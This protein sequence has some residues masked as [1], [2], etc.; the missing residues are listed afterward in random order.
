MC[1]RA[2]AGAE[3]SKRH[4][5]VQGA[6]F[7][8]QRVPQ[9]SIEKQKRWKEPPLGNPDFTTNVKVALR[10]QCTRPGLPKGNHLR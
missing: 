6:M 3:E 8:S 10:N 2:S 5:D 4:G 7:D 1:E 9:V